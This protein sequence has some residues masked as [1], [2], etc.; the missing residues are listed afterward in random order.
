MKQII[1]NAFIEK[2]SGIARIHK[3][4]GVII[5]G[6]NVSVSFP[7][8]SPSVALIRGYLNGKENWRKEYNN[9]QV[10]FIRWWEDGSM[11]AGGREYSG[12]SASACYTRGEISCLSCHSMHD[13]NPVDQLNDIGHSRQACVQCHN[14]PAYTTDIRSHTHHAPDSSGSEC[15]NCHMPH[16]SY[17]LFSAIRNHTIKSPD[18]S[19]S[20]KLGVPNACNL[21]HL[22]KTLEWTSRAM[23]RNW[24]TPPVDLTAEQKEVSAALLWILKGHAAQRV[25]AAWH[26]GWEPARQA[27]GSDWLAPFQAR[28][29]ADP[30]G[31]VRYVAADNLRTLGGF[32]SFQ[33]DF[34]APEEELR[35]AAEKA[36]RHWNEQAASTRTGDEILVNPDGSIMEQRVQELLGERDNRP[37]N[38]KE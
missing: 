31:V 34:I 16:T 25:I 26:V 35:A 28:L 8:N 3:D 29:L 38:I 23:T 2:L 6:D 30:Y 11:L 9:G 10:K 24:G 15:M 1:E 36:V 22:D 20:A 21:C 17:A 32:E 13:S 18:I 7:T 27:S 19:A 5:K 4:G 33:F 12:L 14:E 37:V